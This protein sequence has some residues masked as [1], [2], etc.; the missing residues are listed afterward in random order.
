M[1]GEGRV[2]HRVVLGGFRSC[3][4]VCVGSSAST[5]RGAAARGAGTRL[6]S[7]LHAAFHRACAC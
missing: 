6:D 3:L 5:G 1:R 2:E 4:A 7:E